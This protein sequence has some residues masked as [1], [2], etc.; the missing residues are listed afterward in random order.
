MSHLFF[1]IVFFFSQMI[2][3]FN[4]TATELPDDQTFATFT[5]WEEAGPAMIP[6]VSPLLQ[7]MFP[8]E[9]IENIIDTWIKPQ[10][11]TMHK[12]LH[13]LRKKNPEAAKAV[14]FC[15]STTTFFFFLFF[16]QVHSVPWE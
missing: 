15:F 8:L 6:G 9:G 4:T 7:H 12:I 3:A 2:L 10:A 16:L 5:Q 14:L 13:G 11:C 1:L